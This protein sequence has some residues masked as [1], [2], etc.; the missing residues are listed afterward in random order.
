MLAVFIAAIIAGVIAVVRG[1]SDELSIVL[2]QS[3]SVPFLLAGL[4]ATMVGVVLG[5]RAWRDILLAFGMEVARPIG[6]R[7]FLAGFLG[8]FVPGRVWGAL[9]QAEMGRRAGLSPARMAATFLVN[10]IVVLVTGGLVALL[11]APA[12]LGTAT[13]W[14][15]VPVL[16][17][18]AV[19]A[20]PRLVD[21]M[22]ALAAHLLR[23]DRP[24]W[25]S[26]AT[27]LRRAL[28]WQSLAW[29]ISGLHVW[30]L[31]MLAG[32]PPSASLPVAVGGFAL[33]TIAGVAAVFAPDGVGFREVVLITALSAVLP[34]TD[35][36]VVA[37]ASR[38]LC[39][40]GEL[41]AAAP[42]LI[43]ANR[44]NGVIRH[45]STAQPR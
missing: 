27:G 13:I 36:A 41:A 45:A 32:A 8:K 4:A 25:T 24:E 7:L 40:A 6:I 28:L 42:M 19:A 17:I 29:P 38:V 44:K 22:V 15:A 10:F 12:V 16:L 43:Y 14:L 26:S 11:V 35:A 33:A 23:R 20:R 31:A 5:F 39:T 34:V 3:R 9:A 30:L 1:G 37:V 18:A 21:S 2:G